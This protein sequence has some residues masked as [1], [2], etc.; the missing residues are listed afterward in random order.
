MKYLTFIAI[1]ATVMMTS[2]SEDIENVSTQPQAVDFV[3]TYEAQFDCVGELSEAA[4]ET[5][6]INISKAPDTATYLVDLGDD[7]IFEGLV[8][9]PVLEIREQ[10]FN[11]NGD[12]D[13]VTLAGQIELDVNGEYIFDFTHEVDDEGMSTCESVLIKQ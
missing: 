3:G 6:I 9:G 2:C 1:A 13:V 4:G 8:N 12:F 10:T 5:F 11:E 7:V